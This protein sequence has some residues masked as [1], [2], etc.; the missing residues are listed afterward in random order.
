MFITKAGM[1][2]QCA[3]EQEREATVTTS[4]HQQKSVQY[5]M[6]CGAAQIGDGG[7]VLVHGGDL[8]SV[9]YMVTPRH[10]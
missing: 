6:H 5:C 1:N 7:A 3:Q 4:Q 10:M 9:S 8:D 2:V